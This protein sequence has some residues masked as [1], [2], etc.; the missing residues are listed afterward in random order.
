MPKSSSLRR[1]VPV[2]V[3][4]LSGCG[5]IDDLTG[6]SELA[7]SKFSASPTTV[8][9]GGTVTLSWEVDGADA[10][11]LDGGLGAV[12]AKGN[13]QLRPTTTTA[14]TIRARTGAA[15]SATATVVVT[16]RGT[17][18][19]YASPSPSSTPWVFYSPTPTPTPFPTA[20]PT[21]TPAPSATPSPSASASPSSASCGTPALEGN[22]CALTIRKPVDLPSGQCIELISVASNYACPVAF[23]ANRSLSFAINAHTS[24]QGL[25]WR[26]ADGSVDVLAPESGAISPN[27]L[28]AVTISDTVLDDQ[29]KI[30]VLDGT[31]VLLNFTVRSY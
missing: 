7:I 18:A 31:E 8:D 4:L 27:G 29:V 5:F 2:A 17:S 20:T 14:Y 11:E 26:R 3:A 15:S 24:R 16:V 22:L 13:R 21:P 19:Y 6:T 9:A 28:T 10:I 23:G 25:T 12:T 30:Q 1:A